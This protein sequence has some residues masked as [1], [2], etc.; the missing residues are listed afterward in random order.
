MGAVSFSIPQELVKG[1]TANANITNFVETGTFKGNTTIW[2]ASIFK[3]VYTIE[4]NEAFSIAA[5]K[6]PD[7]T[8]NIEFIVGDSKEVMLS[9]IDRLDGCTMFWLDGHWCMDAGG[10]DDEC[11]LIG[12]LQAISKKQDSVILIDDA[13]CF[14]GPLP[15]PHRAEDWPR[16]DE[17]FVIIKQLFPSHTT[18]IVDDVIVSVPPNLK[19]A[20]DVY[21]KNSYHE[22]YSLKYN[23][24]KY[25]TFQILKSVLGNFKTNK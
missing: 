19:N 9:L 5:S 10:K 25:S 1:L 12:E 7:A 24:R 6:R 18:T 13:R 11:P 22:R 2:A 23:L 14:L 20:L 16:I 17:I 21:W 3:K 15:P 8:P 4:I